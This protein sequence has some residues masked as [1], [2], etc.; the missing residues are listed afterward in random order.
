[1]LPSKPE[2]NIALV[3]GSVEIYLPLAGLVEVDEER[4]RLEK[5]LTDTNSQIQRLEQLLASPFA[6]KAPPAVVQ[7]ERDKLRDYQET[8]AKLSKQ[9]N[10]L[11]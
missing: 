10:E 4:A 5:D 3:V 7:K 8:A 6:E 1:N 11:V 2:G 9:L